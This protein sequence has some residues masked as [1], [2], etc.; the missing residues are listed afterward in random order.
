MRKTYKFVAGDYFP[1]RACDLELAWDAYHMDIQ[2]VKTLGL[3]P[4]VRGMPK[5]RWSQ[6]YK[7]GEIAF[8]YLPIRYICKQCRPQLEQKQNVVPRDYARYQAQ[9]LQAAQE[10]Y[11]T[12]LGLQPHETRDVAFVYYLLFVK[13]GVTYV[14]VGMTTRAPKLRFQGHAY[15]HELDAIYEVADMG[16]A[17]LDN[18]FLD[19]L[20]AAQ[21]ALVPQHVPSK[22]IFPYR[23]AAEA[24]AGEQRHYD[25]LIRGERIEGPCRI[26]NKQR[27]IGRL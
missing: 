23:T 11:G 7:K 15:L 12:Q 2:N 9:A 18:T 26:L 24:A 19:K 20:I 6:A 14:Y 27:P 4:Y 8:P 5:A 1:C 3:L 17:P 22:L 13:A 16:P 21:D 10:R 25:M